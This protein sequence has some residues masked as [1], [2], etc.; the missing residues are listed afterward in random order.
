M[1]PHEQASFLT[2]ISQFIQ[3]Q[4]DKGVAAATAPLLTKIESLEAAMLTAASRE[5]DLVELTYDAV[6]KNLPKPV[7]MAE[8]NRI[9]GHEREQTDEAFLR[10]SDVMHKM[11]DRLE[12]LPE[13]KDGAPGKDA[14]MTEV[15]RV[16]SE[17]RENMGK[18]IIQLREKVEK[19]PVPKD[20]KDGAPGKDATFD[21]SVV[22]E[23]ID[24]RLA[25]LPKPENGKDGASGKDAVLDWEKISAEVASHV[26]NHF[27]ANPIRDGENGP[28]GKDGTSVTMDDVVPVVAAAV[29]KAVASLPRP[30]HVL[31]GLIDRDG[32][33]CLNLSDGKI[34][35]IGKVVGEDGKD[36]DPDQVRKLLQEMVDALPP[37]TDGKDGRDGVD[38][39]DGVGFGNITLQ[40]ISDR[41]YK[42]VVANP[43]GTKSEEFPLRIDLPLYR[44][45]YVSGQTY[46]KG[47]LVTLGGSMWHANKETSVRPETGLEDW[48]IAAK[49]GRDGKQGPPGPA[50][51]GGKDG[52]DGR[53]LTQL[54][55][56]G[57][58]F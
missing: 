16:I 44:D 10:I 6:M 55:F 50:G 21:V 47:D 7:S 36:V 33:L 45:M 26:W 32:A 22:R 17:M 28:P 13:S 41:E 24:Q 49:R 15:N 40:Q 14:D 57:K 53:D 58:K 30:T 29:D 34:I 46:Q 25:A 19:F 31:G 23:L 56:D 54:G 9:V 18:S 1:Q 2:A 3:E 11:Q 20:G 39:K 5:G 27:K 38:G 12:N 4:I 42:W 52:K 43:D 37:P 8:I 48:T 35:K 51:T